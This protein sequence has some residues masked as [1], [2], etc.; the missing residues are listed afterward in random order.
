MQRSFCPTLLRSLSRTLD[1]ENF[2]SASRSC[3]Q[4]NSS[5]V[6]FV[7]HSYDGRRVASGRTQFTTR[8]VADLLWICCTTY[9][10]SCATVDKIPTDSASRGP[11]AVVELRVF[12]TAMHGSFTNISQKLTNFMTEWSANEFVIQLTNFLRNHGVGRLIRGSIT[13]LRLFQL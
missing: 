9:S 3:L 11:S 2:A 4:Q 1:L 8:Y 12:Y 10:Y 7:D 6:E 13:T 5:T